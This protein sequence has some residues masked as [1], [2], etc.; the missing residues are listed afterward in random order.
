LL[1]ALF[2][3]LT[4]F[5]FPNNK[6]IHH[7]IGLPSQAALLNSRFANPRFIVTP[8]LS[9]SIHWIN[10][11]R[12]KQQVFALPDFDSESY[13]TFQNRNLDALW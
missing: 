8:R 6:L 1:H 4:D 13:S 7:S 2:V 11:C 9:L 10:L 3:P 5:T 12:H